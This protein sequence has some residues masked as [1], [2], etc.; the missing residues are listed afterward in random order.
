MSRQEAL[1]H[2]RAVEV[3][4]E[5]ALSE[6]STVAE[7]QG[8]LPLSV[9]LTEWA[10]QVTVTSLKDVPDDLLQRMPA[11]DDPHLLFQP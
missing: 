2:C 11:F 8:D 7:K 4:A 3:Q 5:A 10:N 6:R 1:Q 9:K